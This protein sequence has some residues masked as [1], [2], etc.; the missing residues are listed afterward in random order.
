MLERLFQVPSRGRVVALL[1][2]QDAEVVEDV[3]A[4][5]DVLRAED[6]ASDGERLFEQRLGLVVDAEPPIDPSHDRQHLG[7]QLGLSDELLLH[8]LGAGVEQSADGRLSSCHAA[9]HTDRR[10]SAAR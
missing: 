3:W 10:R 8:A 6:R 9:A 5:R 7:L 4:R 1:R 2:Q